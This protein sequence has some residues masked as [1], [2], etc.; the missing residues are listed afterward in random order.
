MKVVI[1]TFSYSGN[2]KFIADLLGKE[3]EKNDFT[4]EHFDAG[5]IVKSLNIG[6]DFHSID[7]DNPPDQ[8]A[9]L[10]N[11]LQ[12]CDIF[13][14]G[15]IVAFARPARGLVNIFNETVC[16]NSLFNN[17]KFFF[18]FGTCT[19]SCGGVHDILAT[20]VQEKNTNAKFCGSLTVLAPDSFSIFLPPRGFRDCWEQEEFKK[21]SVFCSSII[22]Q[23]NG[24][25]GEFTFKTKHQDVPVY[26]KYGRQ[27][28]YGNLAVDRKKC[29]RC[30]VCVRGCPYN[31][32]TVDIEDSNFP[33]HK[34]E[35][36]TGCSRCLNH[37]P[38]AAISFPRVHTDERELYP[39]P[40]VTKVEDLVTRDLTVPVALK[41]DGVDT[42]P[43]IKGI[44]RSNLPPWGVA[45][46]LFYKREW[47]KWCLLGGISVAAVLVAVG[48]VKV[49]A[50]VIR[51]L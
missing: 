30:H 23:V 44:P 26:Q 8:L 3:F 35:R 5:E 19:T 37:C 9:S 7:Q 47:M 34:P 2:T 33:A 40:F 27:L 49:A 28:L 6:L 14:V 18:T 36:C 32:L 16:P 39:Q 1:L 11:S 45:T 20:V 15:S 10:R 17:L 46:R 4:I 25:V 42:G 51:M 13:G 29:V 22:E 48:G 41:G 38:T 12:S 24:K 21:V 50:A 31:A 43:G